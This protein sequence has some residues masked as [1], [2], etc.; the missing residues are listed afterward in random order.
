MKAKEIQYAATCICH[1]G[2]TTTIN[3]TQAQSKIKNK[4]TNKT[5]RTS[6]FNIIQQ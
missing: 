1:K 3:T 6:E 4:Q 5:A 2:K